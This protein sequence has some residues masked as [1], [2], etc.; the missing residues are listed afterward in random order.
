MLRARGIHSL[1]IHMEQAVRGFDLIVVAI[2]H[3]DIALYEG[4]LVYG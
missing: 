2:C 1:V 3:V 4:D